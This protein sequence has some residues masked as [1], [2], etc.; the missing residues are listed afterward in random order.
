MKP[1]SERALAFLSKQ[2]IR[3]EYHIETGKLEKHL[4]SYSIQNTAEILRFQ[5]IYSGIVIDN[6]PLVIFTPKHVDEHKST[7]IFNTNGQVLLSISDGFYLSENGEIALR[8]RKYGAD[9]FYFIFLYESFETFIEQRA[10]FESHEEY[11]ELP[12]IGYGID[13]INL[14][15]EALS[16]YEF[17][18]ECF[19]KYHMMWKNS[20]NLV[21]ARLYPDGYNVI[22]DSVSEVERT[23]LIQYL[24]SKQVI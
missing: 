6:T 13:N 23:H 16:D 5:E 10:F 1:L 8:E 4:L 22:L 12:C 11:R 7:P 9:D 18:S 20:S 19:D 17:I 14:L 2:E 15:S 24:Q 3:E 21:H